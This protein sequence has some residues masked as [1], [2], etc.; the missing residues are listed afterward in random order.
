M[1]L[2]LKLNSCKRSNNSHVSPFLVA[3][4]KIWLATWFYSLLLFL[5]GDV[6]LNPGPKRNSSNAFSICHWNLNS[7][8]AHN[9]AKVFLLKAYTAIH[10]FDIICISEIYLDSS[11]PFDDNN[12]EISGYTFLVKF[13]VRLDYPS[14]NK[15]EGVCIFYK[16]FLPLRILDVQ[17]LQESICFEFKIGHKTCNFLSPYRS[18]SQRQ[19]DFETFTENLYLN[20]ENLVQRNL[21]LVVAFRDFNAKSSNWFCQDKINFEEDAIENL[22]SLFGSYQMI[23]KP[24]H[25]LDTSSLCT[26]LI[27]KS[28][29]NLI[30]ESGVHSFLHSN[31]HH[32]IIFAKFNLE[33]IYPPSYLLEIWH[34]KDANTE[35]IW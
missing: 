1:F 14:N 29:P 26:D 23:K 20:L 5:S 21:F 34:F 19:D 12:L 13:L 30:T 9:Y 3:V 6:E 4:I 24:T 32:Q 35:L 27:F 33:A 16:S 11:T 7:I 15:R 31:C 18:Q 8:S 22:I 25:I 28:Q 10:K 17:Y 2:I